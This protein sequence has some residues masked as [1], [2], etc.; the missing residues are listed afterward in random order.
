MLSEVR[1]SLSFDYIRSM[2]M[3]VSLPQVKDISAFKKLDK[4]LVA[5]MDR[6][7]T[8]DIP[9]LLQKATPSSVTKKALPSSP[10]SSLFFTKQTPTASANIGSG[11]QNNPP[12]PPA[13]N[14]YGS[15][16][17]RY[18]P[19]SPQPN[20]QEPYNNNAKSPF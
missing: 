11:V 6:V 9:L 3:T 7:L 12:Y 18:P 15:A 13:Y 1:L 4:N 20:Q 10:L 8:H 14:P 5:E 2:L 19:Q 17:G 16:P